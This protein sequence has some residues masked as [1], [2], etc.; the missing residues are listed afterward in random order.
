MGEPAGETWVL[1]GGST[2]TEMLREP[3]RWCPPGGAPVPT[4][5]NGWEEQYFTG[6]LEIMMGWKTQASGH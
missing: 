2:W 1:Q 6:L 3:V 4:S 5:V